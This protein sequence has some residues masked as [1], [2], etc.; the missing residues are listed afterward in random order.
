MNKNR[1]SEAD[2]EGLHNEI[3][4]RL[5]V[6]ACDICAIAPSAE[7]RFSKTVTEVIPLFSY[8]RFRRPLAD[9]REYIL[10]GA[11]VLPH[12]GQW[13]IDADISDEEDGTIY[14]ELP[15]M[16]FSAASFEELKDRVLRTLEQLMILGKPVLYRLF[17]ATAPVLPSQDSTVSSIAGKA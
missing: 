1:F 11:N 12:Q 14:F 13:R 2:W 4:K 8:V 10:V 7:P 6:L 16:P 9:E 5:H 3:Q 17:G 15:N